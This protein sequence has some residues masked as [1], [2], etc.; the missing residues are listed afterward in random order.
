MGVGYLKWRLR[1]R[2]PPSGSG[3]ACEE[4]DA[5]I[6]GLRGQWRIGRARR[7]ARAGPGHAA[8]GTRGP[9]GAGGALPPLPLRLLHCSR[10]PGPA[11]PAFSPTLGSRIGAAPGASPVPTFPSAS[12]ETLT[13]LGGALS[14]A[15]ASAIPAAATAGPAPCSPSDSFL[16]RL[17]RRWRL[18]RGAGRTLPRGLPPPPPPPPPAAPRLSLGAGG[19]GGEG[20]R[21]GNQGEGGPASLARSL[22]PSRAMA[23]A[24]ALS[25]PSCGRCGRARAGDPLASARAFLR[26]ERRWGGGWKVDNGPQGQAHLEDS[27][28]GGQAR[29]D[30]EGASARARLRKMP[31]PQR[32]RRQI[33]TA[34]GHPRTGTGGRGVGLVRLRRGGCSLQSHQ[35]EGGARRGRA[36][37]CALQAADPHCP[38]PHRAGSRRKPALRGMA[39]IFRAGT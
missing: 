35:R 23:A 7:A 16:R 32:L 2:D 11:V 6:A 3:G 22:P 27:S 26:G 8:A 12:D 39:W 37:R 10:A 20:G 1:H 34:R 18:R 28:P 4:A 31:L 21:G 25:P 36:R 13:S 9:R 17:R 5:G 15:P 33:H 14:A 29:A 38:S 19:R 24:A 30:T